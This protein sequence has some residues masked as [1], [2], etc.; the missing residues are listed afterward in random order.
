MPGLFTFD[1]YR[2]ACDTRRA[3]F[4]RTA[5]AAA[6]WGMGRASTGDAQKRTA[7]RA[8]APAGGAEPMTDALGRQ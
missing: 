3:E 1:G 2:R 6:A 8:N 4:V 7:A 5:R